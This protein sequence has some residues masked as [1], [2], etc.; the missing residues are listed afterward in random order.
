M[1]FAKP[2]YQQ[3]KLQFS[4]IVL[5][6]LVGKSNWKM[7]V[8]LSVWSTYP[9]PSRPLSL[10]DAAVHQRGRPIQPGG[11][12]AHPQTAGRRQRRGDR[13]QRERGGEPSCSVFTFSAC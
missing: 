8:S 9:S 1:T 11:A 12:A 4:S 5:F 3:L 2:D 10:G 6:C 7:L 13:G